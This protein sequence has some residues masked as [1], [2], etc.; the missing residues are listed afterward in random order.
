M[1]MRRISVVVLFL[2]FVV[3][4]AW[5]QTAA[6]YTI[7][8]IAGKG[9]VSFT[10]Q[11]SAATSA[12]LFETY[13]VAVDAAGDVY[14]SDSYFNQVFKVTPAGVITVVAGTGQWGDIGDGGPATAAQLDTPL[15]L[16]FDKVNGALYIADSENEVIRKVVISTG[17][18]STVAGNGNEGAGTDN[19]AATKSALD[20]PVAVA[21]D[22]SGN[23]YIADSANNKIRKVTVSTGIITTVAGNGTYDYTGDKGLATAATLAYPEGVAVDASGNIYIAD[24]EN[25]VIRKVTASTGIITTYAGN[26]VESDGG[27][28]GP[29]TAANF[30]YPWDVAVD[31]AGNLYI[32]DYYNWEIRKV[33]ASTG[34]IDTVAGDENWGLGGDGGPAIDASIGWPTG[35]AVDASNNFYIAQYEMGV[36]RK[37]SAGVM[38][39]IA[40][41]GLPAQLGDGG[42]AL[43]AFLFD[44][45]AVAA[46][47]A[48]NVYIADD[49]TNRVRKVTADGNIA[50]LA[51]NSV[52]GSTGDGFP[53]GSAEL[54]DPDSLA[55]DSAGN[56]YIAEDY[57]LRKITPAGTI[58][59][60]ASGGLAE[61]GVS[62]SVALDNAAGNIYVADPDN[63]V[64]W[65]VTSAGVASIFAGN[66]T[67][68]YSG[69]GGQAT[70]AEL[71]EPSGLAVDA[72]GNVY[73][74][75]DE[76]SNVRKV[77][78]AGIISTFAGSGTFDCTG[79]G[80]Q[81]AAAAL[82]SPEG[83]A[84]DSAGNL[85]IADYDCSEI[86][87]V[88]PSGIISTIAGTGNDGYSGDGGPAT[89]AEIDSPSDVKVDS[90]GNIYIADTG[91]AVIRKLTAPGT[92]QIS[93]AGV[94]NAASFKS[95][96]IAPGEMV[97]IFG[98]GIGP[99]TGAGAQLT[100]AGLVSTSVAQTQVLFGGTAAPLIYVSSGQINAVVPYEV[101]GQSTVPLQVQYQGAGS[102]SAALNVAATSPAIFVISPQ[103]QTP[104]QGAILNQDSSINGASNPA[105]AGSVIQIYA[106]GEGVT[107]PGSTD[108]QL[109]TGTT[110]PAPVAPLSVTIGGQP[111][112]VA[113]AGT[114]PG[115]VAGFLQVN[116]V[117]PGGA[118][119][120]SVP[121][122]LTVGGASSPAGVTV[123]LK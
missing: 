24:T 110:F 82:S 104:Q 6:S 72:Q 21:V 87:M 29:A 39:T 74:A 78:P 48:G 42:P 105:A 52:Y 5:G 10:G 101:A 89:A 75:D 11:G 83:M 47:A 68:G 117:V 111:A 102:N 31:A 14:F 2:V 86:R 13:G 23:F 81:A 113:F 76:N 93:A 46:D 43:Q 73:I 25:E 32:A 9:I 8:T 33:T 19:K 121:I 90:H 98:S 57:D 55:M 97:S 51:G 95:G 100:S 45:V 107:S 123:A 36:V 12:Q 22:A 53:A 106:T 66:G 88:A 115:G 20:T 27:D 34:I 109:A 38:G 119:T 15:G 94:V 40:G 26:G 85:Y 116:A 79:D 4:T 58:S 50:T 118:G 69:D 1:K 28:G 122:M 54:E 77:T 112:S 3:F 35:V 99:A 103:G 41:V 63:F 17:V 60:V 59:S 7:G 65:K 92:A 91:N 96:S 62:T 44:P 16:A 120:G 18:I 71:D 80:G 37:V 108:G 56:L 30:D 70:L 84:V 114:A 64:V 61:L 67:A 49:E